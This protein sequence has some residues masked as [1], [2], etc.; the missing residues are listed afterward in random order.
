MLGSVKKGV[1]AMWSKVV[2]DH[3]EPLPVDK[4]DFPDFLSDFYDA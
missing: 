3:P 4:V 2:A 1:G